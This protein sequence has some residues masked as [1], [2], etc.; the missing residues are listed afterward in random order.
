M[1]VCGGELTGFIDRFNEIEHLYNLKQYWN[2][3]KNASDYVT[4]NGVKK[5]Y[6]QHLIFI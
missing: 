3:K 6:K 4:R 5:K 1:C 2:W